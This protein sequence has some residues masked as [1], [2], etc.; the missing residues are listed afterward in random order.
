MAQPPMLEEA[1]VAP[2]YDGV[3]Q[4]VMIEQIWEEFVRSLYARGLVIFRIPLEEAEDAI[5]TYG[6]TPRRM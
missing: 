6:V 5:P 1:L 4:V 2:S 3:R